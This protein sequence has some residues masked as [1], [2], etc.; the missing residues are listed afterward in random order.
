MKPE[1]KK[2]ERFG[3]KITEKTFS[4]EIAYELNFNEKDV[5]EVIKIFFEK[6]QKNLDDKHRITITNFGTFGVLPPKKIKNALFQ[7]GHGAE[8]TMRKPKIVFKPHKK[9]AL[10]ICKKNVE[11]SA[12]YNNKK[13][14]L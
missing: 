2:I 3:A 7:F 9:F 6:L 12:F 5:R 4:I 13:N 14:E 1:S 11:F 10:D 8:N